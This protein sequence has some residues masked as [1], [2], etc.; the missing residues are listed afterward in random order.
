[1]TSVKFRPSQSDHEESPMTKDDISGRVR[2]RDLKILSN[3]HYTLRKA[4]FDFQRNDGSWQHQARESYDIGHAAVVLPLDRAHGR[5]LLIRQFRWPVFEAGYRRLLIEAIAGKLDGDTPET[6]IVR[7]AMEEAGVAIANAR[8]VS[9]CFVSPGAVMERAS[10]FLAD[11]DSTA[12]RAEGGGQA[13][14]GEDIEVLEMTLDEAMG[15]I[16]RGEIVDMKTIML[17]QAAK[18]GT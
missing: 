16:A 17:L 3:N 1:M 11:Y 18:L 12:R 8:L 9:H 10:C 15:L 5:V 7:E 2:L 4:D 6:C 13:H 14:E